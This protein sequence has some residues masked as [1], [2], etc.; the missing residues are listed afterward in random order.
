MKV[1]WELSPP[2][3]KRLYWKLHVQFWRK[4]QDQLYI[5][6]EKGKS[7]GVNNIAIV[8]F[9]FIFH[10][11]LFIWWK[12]NKKRKLLIL[13]FF[14]ENNYMFFTRLNRSSRITNNILPSRKKFIIKVNDFPFIIIFWKKKSRSSIPTIFSW[15]EIIHLLCWK[16]F[17][18]PNFYLYPL[19]Y[20]Q[21][22]QNFITFPP[23]SF[24]FKPNQFKF[25]VY[26]KT[27]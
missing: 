25:P 21:T 9:L 20:E 2:P 5:S 6:T 7:F 12:V 22:K 14:W 18:P 1:E 16:S 15:W 10:V 13:L 17:L 27:T 23:S 26:I 11:S 3:R 4:P 19:T 8:L 24:L